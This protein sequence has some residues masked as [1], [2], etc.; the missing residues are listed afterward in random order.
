[1]PLDWAAEVLQTYRGPGQS[2]RGPC[3]AILVPRLRSLGLLPGSL[4][5]AQRLLFG[6][7]EVPALEAREVLTEHVGTEFH[8]TVASWASLYVKH[9]VVSLWPGTKP[10]LPLPLVIESNQSPKLRNRPYEFR[11]GHRRPD[12][13]RRFPI[14][15]KGSGC[16]SVDVY[17]N[18]RPGVVC[19]RL[20]PLPL[21]WVVSS[22][23][24]CAL[25]SSWLGT[26]NHRSK[27]VSPIACRRLPIP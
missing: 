22:L 8:V 3:F 13:L 4:Q 11:L 14:K 24:L 25:S 17:E 21:T 2:G 20:F 7:N 26:V 6:V 23:T 9:F 27:R 19:G 18:C 15:Y 12:M 1:M 16:V 5:R 10:A